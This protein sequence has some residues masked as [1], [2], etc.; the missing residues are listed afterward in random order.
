LRIIRRNRLETAVSHDPSD[1]D[2]FYHHMYVPFT[3]RRFGELGAVKGYRFLRACFRRG[4]LVWVLQEGRRLAAAVVD[5]ND[6]RLALRALGCMHGDLRV[7]KMGAFAAV[8]QFCFAYAR[9]QGCTVAGV[10][11]SRAVLQD[12]VLRYKRKWGAALMPTTGSSFSLLL[13]WR[14]LQGVA[15]DFLAHTSP[16]FIQ[17]DGLAAIHALPVHLRA[18]REDALT[19]RETYW[20]QGLRRLY[21]AAPAGWEPGTVAPPGTVLIDARQQGP[22]PLTSRTMN[23]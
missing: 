8:Y 13:S 5:R 2:C 22:P 4:A 20:I 9:Q 19:A 21:L 11:T 15:A 16:I 7:V 6:R 3:R 12:G 17:P 23:P 10:G 1:F 14:R 18:V